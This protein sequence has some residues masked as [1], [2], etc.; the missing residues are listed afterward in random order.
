MYM[1]VSAVIL[2][3]AQHTATVT[4]ACKALARLLVMRIT[5]NGILRCYRNS[6]EFASLAG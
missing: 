5:T 4:F 6:P 2:D 3:Q 1:Q